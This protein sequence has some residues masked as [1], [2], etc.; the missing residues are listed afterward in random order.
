MR[1]GSG[2]LTIENKAKKVAWK[3]HYERLLNKE[4][5]WNSEE[6]T[7]DPVVD[8]PILT[9]IEMFPKAEK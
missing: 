3:Q 2:N 5:S 9:T 4:F 7:A 6:L 1:D 8:P